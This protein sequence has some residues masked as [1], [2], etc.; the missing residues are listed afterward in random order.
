MALTKQDRDFISLT[1]TESIGNALRPIA[2]DV[3]THKQTLFGVNNDNG[4]NKDVRDLKAWKLVQDLRFW[5]LAWLVGIV[6]ALTSVGVNA[7]IKYFIK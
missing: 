6:T 5:K 4:M 3:Q 2:A 7:A 1:M